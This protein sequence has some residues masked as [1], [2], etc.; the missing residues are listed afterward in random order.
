[1][2]ANWST[3]RLSEV[4]LEQK[5]RVGTFDAN[6]LP[7]LGVSNA[8]G[9]HQTEKPRIAD[10]SRYLRVDHR[11]FAYNPMRINVGSIGW[12]ERPEQTGV[13]SPDYVVFSCTD[14]IEPKLLYLF[15]RSAIGLRAINLETAGSV[16]ERLY[17]G[18]LSRIRFPLPT[19][20]EQQR[21]L[22]QIE[23]M[24]S[25]INEARTLRERGKE[26][27]ENLC[28]AVL[29]R[30]PDHK[31]TP[32]SELVRLR[33]PDVTVQQDENYQFA[34]VYC[35]GRGVFRAQIKTGMEFAYKI[36]TRLKTGNFVYP[37]LMAWEGALGVVPPECDGCVV[38]T[39][40]PVFEVLEDR[41]L[42][43]VLDTYFRSPNVW[44]ELSGSSTGT[45]V[46]RRRLNPSD[47]LD[48]RM[49]LPSRATQELLRRVRLQVDSLRKLQAETATELDALLP[50]IL[51]RVFKGGM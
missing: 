27:I 51:D 25:K 15:L 50:S 26:E 2:T 16:R 4:L 28:R 14:R 24:A 43:E 12:A 33:S 30:N 36:L 42:P 39:E 40:F 47:F 18:S 8:E 21:I 17:F 29:S 3:V 45:N 20:A 44:P 9:L 11:W 41:V 22:A 13:I 5:V 34:G 46:R 38:S 1:M 49:P 35:F 48:Y 10:M 32:M 23:E 31:L 6:G 37:K 7:L 19:V